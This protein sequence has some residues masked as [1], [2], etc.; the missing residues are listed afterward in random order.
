MSN[1][2]RR[3]TTV[4]EIVNLMAVDAERLRDAPVYLWMV[5]SC[6]LQI[7]VAIVLLYNVLGVSVFAGLA[8]MLVLFPVNL[9]I[10]RIQTRLEVSCFSCRYCGY[11][12][13]LICM[14]NLQYPVLA[15]LEMLVR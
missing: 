9:A 13:E 11:F 5:W 12:I 10:A 3:T 2:A 7:T 4:G 8:V 15:P 6:P 1:E 14:L